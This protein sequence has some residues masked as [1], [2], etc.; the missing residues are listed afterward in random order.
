MHC[1]FNYPLI[2]VLGC[3]SILLML[4]LTWKTL[5]WKD[6]ASFLAASW[7]MLLG[8]L[9]AGIYCVN[10]VANVA[11]DGLRDNLSGLAKSF[12]IALKDA[13]HDHVGLDTPDD[14]PHYE[15]MLNMMRTWQSQIS[16]AASIYTFRRNAKGEIVFILCPPADLNR[17][18]K[19]DGP[20]EEMV[21]KGTVYDEPEEAIHEIL[22]AFSGKSG[23]SNAPVLDTWG[24]WVTAAEPIFD[25]TNE[26]ID[27]VLGVD[28]CGD[29]WN[30][31]VRRAVFWPEMFLLLAITL[32]FAVQIFTIRR[33]IIENKLTQYAADLERTMDELVE[34][35]Q[36]ADVAVQ[37]KSFFLANISHE[38]R[39]PMS[40][41]LGCVDMLI[42]VCEGKAGAFSQ[43]QLV[44]IIRKSSKNLM[45]IIN[46]VLTLSSIETNQIIPESVSLNLRQL[47][48]DVRIMTS[49]HF[50]EK[51]QLHFRIEWKEPVSHAIIGDPVRIRQ[52][53]LA[54]ISNAV[55]FTETGQVIVRCSCIPISEGAESTKAL[56]SAFA[57]SSASLFSRPTPFLSPLIA[58]AKGLR[59]V[60][61]IGSMSG[62]THAGIGLQATSTPSPMLDMWRAS[63]MARL[64][65]F[66]VSDTGIGIAKEQFETLFKPFVQVDNTSTRKYG[67]TG[68]GLSIVKGLVQLLGGEVHAASE[69]GRGSTFSV[70]LPVYECENAGVRYKK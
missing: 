4:G 34:A 50:E 10:H 42:N 20:D 23:F 48:D 51:P 66:D 8:I 62:I 55:K 21:S 41:I 35:K 69:L 1:I 31:T 47:V 24:L 17:D 36:Q 65:R 39:T 16:A 30:A 59:G 32:F 53:L 12:A 3:G 15:K 46:D 68:L 63:P 38:I 18:G 43:E 11:Q 7:I 33:H 6:M 70:F 2:A 25:E 5:R 44:D 54:L 61:N 57:P 9:I 64:L 28:F 19:Y 22:D 27:A 37:A 29:I 49:S 13:G 56:F 26:R 14:D 45:T 52:I 60:V 67:G 58:H 40:A